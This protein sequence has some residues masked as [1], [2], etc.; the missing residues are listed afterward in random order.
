M[1]IKVTFRQSCPNSLMSA[2]SF[3]QGPATYFSSPF[4]N[5]QDP[6]HENRF[7]QSWSQAGPSYT[8]KKAQVCSKGDMENEGRQ[9]IRSSKQNDAF[10]VLDTY[11]RQQKMQIQGIIETCT[12]MYFSFGLDP[13]PEPLAKQGATN[14]Y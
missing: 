11:C 5:I 7:T 1:A 8:L 4:S 2:L 12:R 14:L 6:G 10:Q 9:S 13:E 3:D